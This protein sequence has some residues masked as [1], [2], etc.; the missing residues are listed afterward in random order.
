MAEIQYLDL[1]QEVDPDPFGLET[2][3]FLDPHTKVLHVCVD[4]VLHRSAAD[5]DRRNNEL[6]DRSQ[7]NENI[8]QQPQDSSVSGL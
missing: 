3:R 5:V 1:R 4:D 6:A 7:D 8:Q 2:A